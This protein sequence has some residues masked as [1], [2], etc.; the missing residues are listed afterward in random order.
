MATASEL[1][2]NHTFGRCAALCFR[3]MMA[4]GYRTNKDV[5][6]LQ[7]HRRPK[8]VGEVAEALQKTGLRPWA[9]GLEITEGVMMEDARS[10][11]A[12]LRELANLGVGLAV[13][14]FGTGY[15]ALSALHRLPVE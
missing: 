4:T 6:A 13:D 11:I 8:L 7:I 10:A 14:D 5:R 9:L 12:T 2:K 15:S 3:D 1:E